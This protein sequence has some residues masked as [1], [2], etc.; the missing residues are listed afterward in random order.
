MARV[1]FN[2]RGITVSLLI[3]IVIGVALGFGL[4]GRLGNLAEVPLRWNLLVVIGLALQVLLFGPLHVFPDASLPALYLLSNGIAAIWVIRNLAIAGLPC[5]GLGALSNLLAIAANGG[6]MP[7]DAA[8]LTQT[9]G[10]AFTQA[11][12]E[13]RVPTNAVIADSGTRLS[14]LTDRF[15]LPPSLV[16]FSVGDLLISVG[17]IWLIA[18]AM[19]PVRDS[20]RQS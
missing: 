17:V 20:E 8:L 1:A 10:A 7:V 14:W 11:V 16:V 2:T 4:G 18:A 15:V 3:A 5:I 6:R 13:H 12:A 9:R 19:R